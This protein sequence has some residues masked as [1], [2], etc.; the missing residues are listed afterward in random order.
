MPGRGAYPTPARLE[1]LRLDHRQPRRARSAELTDADIERQLLADYRAAKTPAARRD[2]TKALL[3]RRKAMRPEEASNTESMDIESMPRDVRERIMSRLLK[4][5]ERL[6]QLAGKRAAAAA[7]EAPPRERDSGLSEPAVARRARSAEL[8][9]ADIERQLLADYQSAK[10]PAARRDA[11]R[12]L[13]DWRK[14]MRPEERTGDEASLD[15]ESI[16]REMRERL[17]RRLLQ[18]AVRLDEHAGKRDSS[19]A[20]SPETRQQ[21]GAPPRGWDSDAREVSRDR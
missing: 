17:M 20:S 7:G 15:I 12:A 10:T 11:T 21:E 1:P 14:A 16:P 3:E 9:D 18:R 6:E 4:R 13:L 5:A 8:T 19:Q 2:A